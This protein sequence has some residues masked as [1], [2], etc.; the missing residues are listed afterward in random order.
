MSSRQTNLDV[1]L[2]KIWDF[3][4]NVQEG[5]ISEFRQGFYKIRNMELKIILISNLIPLLTLLLQSFELS[6]FHRFCS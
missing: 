6:N 5:D 1:N 2:R 3:T 4:A